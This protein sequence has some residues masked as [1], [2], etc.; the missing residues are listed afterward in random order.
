MSPI[1]FPTKFVFPVTLTAGYDR[2]NQPAQTYLFGTYLLCPPYRVDE[3]I[4]TVS[5]TVQNEDHS[6]CALP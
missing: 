1:K 6:D 4:Q 3:T 2:Y 5:D